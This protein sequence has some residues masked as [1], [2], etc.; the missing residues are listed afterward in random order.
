MEDKEEESIPSLVPWEI[1]FAYRRFLG[2][3]SRSRPG[4]G[5][6]LWSWKTEVFNSC[7]LTNGPGELYNWDGSLLLSCFEARAFLLNYMDQ[8]LEAAAPGKGQ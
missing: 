4:G 7:Q 1:R 6:E 5:E 8:S 3:P 2:L